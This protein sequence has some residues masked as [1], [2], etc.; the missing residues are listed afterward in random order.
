MLALAGAFGLAP[1]GLTGVR[2]AKNQTVATYLAQEA[3]ETV[4]AIRDNR[5]FYQPRPSDRLNWLADLLVCIDKS[6]VVD[7]VNNTVQACSGGPATC[8][9][10]MS[11]DIPTS[12]GKI[13]GNGSDPMWG[14][15]A[16]TTIFTRTVSIQKVVNDEVA[17]GNDDTEVLV[18]V[19]IWWKEGNVTKHNIIKETLFD[20]WTIK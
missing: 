16:Q 13:Y 4:H 2:F 14:A 20:W 18:T 5:M 19:D 8:P 11:V 3:M 9:P 15:G 10:L 7:A 6:C 12:G 17:P 1:Q